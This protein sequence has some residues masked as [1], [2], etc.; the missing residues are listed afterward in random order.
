MWMLLHGFMGAPASWDAVI[1]VAGFDGQ[2]IRPRLLGHGDDWAR[3]TSKSFETEVD[4]LGAL[5]AQMTEPR[6]LGGYSLG[7]RV[8]VG[9]L[10][11]YPDLFAGALLIGLHPGLEDESARRSRRA[12][13]QGRAETLRGQGV[14]AFVDAWER[15]PLFATQARLSEATAATQRQIRTGHDAEGLA[16]SLE[17]LGLG[18]MPHYP[19]G[20]WAQ[21]P[22][23]TL[24][25]GEL[26][27]KFRDLALLASNSAPGIEVV[28]VEG[29]GHNLLIEGAR[30][31]AREIKELEARA[32]GWRLR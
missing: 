31:V 26:D 23:I 25:A 24:M 20:A 28:I 11:R 13:D 8:G 27:P 18:S 17:V 5:A 21:K 16:R 12:L 29:A 7:A 30:Q 19:I 15:L 6:Y 1:S 9:L 10:A 3:N 32:T 4:R 14:S 2:T 22:A